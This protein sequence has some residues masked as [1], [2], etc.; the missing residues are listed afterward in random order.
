M[1]ADWF[2]SPEFAL[3]DRDE[4]VLHVIGEEGLTAF[5]FDGLKRRLGLHQETLSRILSRLE[6]QG[7]VEK[8]FEGYGITSKGKEL[9]SLHPLN[10]KQNRI[11][12]LQTLLPRD[13]PVEQIILDLKG[14]WFGELRWLGYSDNEEGSTLKWITEDGRIQVDASFTYES[15]SVE[16]TLQQE[17]DMNAALKASYQFMAY[18]SKLYSKPNR[19]KPVAYYNSFDPYSTPA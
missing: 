16:A 13:V 6:E 4:K 15:L 9:L 1:D 5:T 12:L 18:V 2:E 3:S 17:K 7:I 14:K 8:G 10:Q 11:P 19:M